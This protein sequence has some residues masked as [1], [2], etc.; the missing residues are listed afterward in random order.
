MDEIATDALWC[1]VEADF[2]T[3]KW[4]VCNY[5][6][7]SYDQFRGKLESKIKEV[8]KMMNFLALLITTIGLKEVHEGRSSQ[9][10][11]TTSLVDPETIIY[12]RD[13]DEKAI[14]NLLLSNDVASNNH[15]FVIPIVGMG[16][17]GKTT[18]ARHIYKNQR[19][20]DHFT[21]KAWV[22]V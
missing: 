19:V 21:L 14:V 18:L 22:C 11:S 15:S 3:S 9:N 12:G 13:D 2:G 7:T 20:I 4:K 17:V 5:I 6:S 16:G 10:E 8:V 1:Q